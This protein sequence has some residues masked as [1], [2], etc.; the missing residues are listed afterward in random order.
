M[1]KVL[2]CLTACLVPSLLLAEDLVEFLNGAK[3]TGSMKEIRKEK[4]EFDFEVQLG[5]RVPVIF[6]V[7]TTENDQQAFDRSEGPGGHNVGEEC[8]HT[9]VEMVH[10]TRRHG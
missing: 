8:A 4:K 6:W 2:C 1:F 9:A 10:L 3:A 5:G 7:L